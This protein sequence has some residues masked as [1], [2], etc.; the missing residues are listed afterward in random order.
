MGH[1]VAIFANSFN[2]L[3]H[4]SSLTRSR[5]VRRYIEEGVKAKDCRP[6]LKKEELIEMGI[7]EAG[8]GEMS[9]LSKIAFSHVK[10]LQYP[11]EISD[12]KGRQHFNLTQFLIE[13]K[14]DPGT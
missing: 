3:D 13:T 8:A 2:Y 7:K 11:L 5:L 6:T 10:Q 1:S 9:Q 14:V 12:G 4:F